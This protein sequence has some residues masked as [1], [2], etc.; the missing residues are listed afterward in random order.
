M[1]GEITANHD[2]MVLLMFHFC[3]HFSRFRIMS[4]VGLFLHI[5][6]N[7]FHYFWFVCFRISVTC[8]YISFETKIHFQSCTL[9]L[10]CM[11]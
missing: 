1:G 5:S 6:R 3:L 8:R 7:I 11:I 4:S 9:T 2:L 10:S